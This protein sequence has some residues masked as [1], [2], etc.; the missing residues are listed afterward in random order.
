MRFVRDAE[1]ASRLWQYGKWL[2]A[3]SAL[4]FLAQNADKLIFGSFMDTTSFGIYAIATI[5]VNV[6]MSVIKQLQ[7]KVGFPTISSV[8]QDRPQELPRLYRRFQR[9]ADLLCLLSFVATFLG[10]PWL[11]ELLYTS[12]YH[13]AGDFIRLLSVAFLTMRFNSLSLLLLNLGDSRAMMV[14]S[15]IRAGA[16]VI[17]LLIGL[18]TL[19]L[20]G[21]VLAVVLTPL[22]SAPYTLAKIRPVLGEGAV[23]QGYLWIAGTIPLA[24][25]VYSQVPF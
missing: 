14:V 10:G 6:G 19:G 22:A 7:D 12:N 15:G 17:G 21:G 16:L 13:P 1:I 11:I 5:W 24:V 3:S 2:I 25:L 18:S 4:S 20:G 9:L 23:R 8:I